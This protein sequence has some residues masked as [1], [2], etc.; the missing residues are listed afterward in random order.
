MMWS[1]RHT[2]VTPTRSGPKK[3]ISKISLGFSGRQ[4]TPQKS[5]VRDMNT[6][7]DVEVLMRKRRNKCPLSR[8]SRSA[9]QT[10]IPR[11]IWLA[12][13]GLKKRDAAN[14]MCSAVSLQ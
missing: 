14:S 2:E 3:N 12:T 6:C 5:Y 8:R 7:Y 4:P 10:L 1:H 13:S 9:S 11:R